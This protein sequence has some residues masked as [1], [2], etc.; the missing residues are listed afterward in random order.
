M[1]NQN[2]LS[3]KRNIVTG[4]LALAIMF[5][6]FSADAQQGKKKGHDKHPH[7]KGY[8]QKHPNHK[9]DH[10]IN[11][12][13]VVVVPA[14]PARVERV[15]VPA[16]APPARVIVQPVP[17]PPPLPVPKNPPLPPLPPHPG[18]PRR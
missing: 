7:K 10:Y 3:M 17:V 5:A 11:K 12:E 9:R 16:P 14:P 13:R 15:Y 2:A 4:L 18:L 8:N 1:T 6:G